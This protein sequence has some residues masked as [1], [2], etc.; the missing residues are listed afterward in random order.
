VYKVPIFPLTDAANRLFRPTQLF[1]LL[2]DAADESIVAL[3]TQ[4]PTPFVQVSIAF[5]VAAVPQPTPDVPLKLP[6]T[7]VDCPDAQPG[8]L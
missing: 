7:Y 5:I 4:N 6:E 8:Q 3:G 2:H 1:I